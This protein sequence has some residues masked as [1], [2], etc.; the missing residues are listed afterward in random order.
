MPVHH[1][2][3]ILLFPD[4]SRGFGRGI[5]AGISRYAEVH[6]RWHFYF[7]QP[8]YL[9]HGDDLDLKEFR[10]WKP[11]GVVCSVKQAGR[12][13]KLQVPMV[14]Y[15]PGNYTGNLPCIVSDNP[16][17]GRLAARHFMD[18]G[19]RNFAY[20][21]F[22]SLCWSRIRSASF[23]AHLQESGQESHH[24][25]PIGDL[26]SWS[27]E[28]EQIRA[29]ILELPKPIGIFCCNDDRA[30]SV[31]E[32]CAA[33][34][35][36]IPEDVALLGADDDEL[37]C[38]VMSPPLTS[39]RISSEQ[40]GYDAAGLLIR[41]IQGKEKADGQR[42]VAKA[43][44]IV[45]RQSTNILMVKHPSLKKA[46]QYIRQHLGSPIQVTDVVQSAGLS[47]RALNDLFHKEL[48]QSI[49][50]YLTHARIQHISHLLVDTDLQIQE[51]ADAVGYEDDRHFARYFKRSTG[52]TPQAF[53]R[54]HL[55]P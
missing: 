30:M 24:F 9:Q 17:I 4:L 2:P 1:L 54:K 41:M 31:S 33:L 42:L 36:S 6:G 12:M 13:R 52:D 11:D 55:A 27:Q 10:R 40:A 19:L 7:R 37:I 48:K 8:S 14:C 50:K 32:I 51:I 49:G 16:E 29:W 39:I 35:L 46:V 20:C 44:N 43:A 3:R 18:L 25:V 28:E 45:I 38:E 47:H 21:G 15:D 53:R 5:M 26:N 22:P 34:G 23:R